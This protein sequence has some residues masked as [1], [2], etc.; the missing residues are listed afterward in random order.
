METGRKGVYAFHGTGPVAAKLIDLLSSEQYGPG[1][2]ITDEK[3]SAHC[4]KDTRVTGSGYSSLQTAIRRVLRDKGLRWKRVSGAGC[5]KCL[6]GKEKMTE[7][8]NRNKHI[9]RTAR[10]VACV[11]G[12][13]T[14]ND[15]DKDSL[16]EL[17]AFR[18][19]MG[20]IYLLSKNDTVKK[21]AARDIEEVMDPKRLLAG[22][23]TLANA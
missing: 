1:D 4:G 19:S 22:F 7:I 14:S 21:L 6:E 12:T 3:M 10:E 13:I 15:I 20:T 2:T 17:L 18:A 8:R 11:A 9:R 5:I 16:K 23:Q